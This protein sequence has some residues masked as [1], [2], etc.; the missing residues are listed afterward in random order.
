MNREKSG[1]NEGIL[2]FDL[3]QVINIYI[4]ETMQEYRMTALLDIFHC[5]DFYLTEIQ[6][7]YPFSPTAER[8]ENFG[9]LE[10]VSFRH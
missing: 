8:R 2:L 6:K 3:T 1:L 7:L 10:Q 4:F 9:P 5:F